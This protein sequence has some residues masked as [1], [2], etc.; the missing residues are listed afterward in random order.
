MLSLRSTLTL[1]ALTLLLAAW[2]CWAVAGAGTVP[3]FWLASATL[4]PH[5]IAGFAILLAAFVLPLMF[6]QGE[7][8]SDTSFVYLAKATHAAFWFSAV[9]MF[10]LLASSRVSPVSSSGIALASLLIFSLALIALALNH[11][12]PRA[13]NAILFFWIVALPICAYMTV[14]VF[15]TS[16][17]GGSGL[18]ESSAPQAA[19]LRATIHWILN[20]S[21]STATLGAL[22]GTIADGT[23]FSMWISLLGIL[24]FLVP[25]AGLIFST[26][27][28]THEGTQK[29]E[30]R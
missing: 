22:T 23:P 17:A 21:P 20:L 1:C 19:D 25:L 26:K 27:T 11:I 7:L 4:A 14:E 12:R 28:Q 10:M 13:A 29:S 30:L 9:T 16:P 2:T 24:A 18:A 6:K 15:L 5:F 8:S 3:P